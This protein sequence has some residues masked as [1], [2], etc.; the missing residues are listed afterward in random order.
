MWETKKSVAVNRLAAAHRGALRALQVI[1]HQLSDRPHSKVPP[2]YK[3]LGQLIRQLSL[4]S[5]KLDV[6]QGSAVPETAPDILQKL[7]VRN[8]DEKLS[9]FAFATYICMLVLDLSVT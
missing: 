8:E 2:H 5:A 6:D 3:E 7:E 4:C 1:I 9:G